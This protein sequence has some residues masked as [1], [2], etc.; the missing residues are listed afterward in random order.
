MTVDSQDEQLVLVSINVEV[1]LEEA[2]EGT[3]DCGGE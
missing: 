3:P 2:N 1:I